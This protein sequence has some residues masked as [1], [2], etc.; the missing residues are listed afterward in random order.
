MKKYHGRQKSTSLWLK[1]GEEKA[2]E[3]FMKIDNNKQGNKGG[4]GEEEVPTNKKKG[5]YELKSLELD[6]K[7]MS[8][9]TRS[10]GGYLAIKQ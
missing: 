8:L 9:G 4:G 3:L 6:T 1:E 5:A 2:E 10:R 7:F